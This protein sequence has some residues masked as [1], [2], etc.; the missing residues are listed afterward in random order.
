MLNGIRVA[1]VCMVRAV[2]LW[3]QWGY[4]PGNAWLF[5]AGGNGR[6]GRLGLSRC[7]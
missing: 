1:V 3:S 4:D 6:P 7:F 5:F 2:D